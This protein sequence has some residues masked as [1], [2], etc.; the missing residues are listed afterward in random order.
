MKSISSAGTPVFVWDS[1][2]RLFHWGVAALVV[3]AYATWRLNWMDAH[4]RVGVSVLALVFFRILWGI[5]GSDPTRFSHIVAS[6]RAAVQHLAHLLRREP[7]DQAGHNPAGGW[8]VLTLLVLLL[9]ETVTGIYIANDVADEGPFT[10]IIPAPIA[11][12][13][14]A[15]HWII[16]DTL[17]VAVGL[18]L[19]AIGLY[20]A[21]KGQN[22][23]LP[24]IT[25]W[26]MLPASVPQPRMVGETRAVIFLVCGA[27]AAALLAKVL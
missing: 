21:V 23:L 7:D 15:L 26:K 17:L 14:T 8:M 10:E 1:A 20:A 5:F 25:G 13:I 16:W 11:N 6:P 3:A 4:A 22:L 24:M 9:G 19:L 2:T 27:L 12:A 18:H